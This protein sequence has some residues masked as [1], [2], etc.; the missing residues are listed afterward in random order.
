MFHD[1]M[2]VLHLAQHPRGYYLWT[3]WTRGGSPP[4]APRVTGKPAVPP[5]PF[6]GGLQGLKEALRSIGSDIKVSKGT[7]ET[8]CA[9]LPSQRGLPLPSTPLLGTPPESRARPVIRPWN[10]AARW[11]QKRGGS[12]LEYLLAALG[13][14]AGLCPEVGDDLARKQPA[15][16]GVLFPSWW[17]GKGSRQRL[18]VRLQVQGPRRAQDAPGQAAWRLG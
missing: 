1:T 16:F 10:V 8:V 15:G 11:L 18:S 2:I 13:Q 5:H 6:E 3:E 7:I 17:T 4:P 14:A 12:A 9:W